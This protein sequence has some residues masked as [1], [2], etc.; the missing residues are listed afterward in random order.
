MK[1]LI[2]ADIEGVAGVVHPDQTRRGAPDD[3]RARLWRAR[4]W[5]VQEA[6][7]A[8]IRAGVSAAL[9]RPLPAPFRIPAPLAVTIR[10]QSPALADLFCQWP[11]LHR[12]D[13]SAFT[14]EA[15]SVADDQ[16]PVG[17]VE[18]A[19]LTHGPVPPAPGPSGA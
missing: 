2:S 16:R 13:G 7:C 1:L 18:P 14:V 6:S 4:L 5:M 10:A 9:S 8:A 12:R 3:E 19:A 11:G 15:D 17:D